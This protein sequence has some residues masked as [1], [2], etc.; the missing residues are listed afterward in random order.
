MILCV[1][2]AGRCDLQIAPRSKIESTDD[3]S[4]REHLDGCQIA[5]PRSLCHSAFGNCIWCCFH[6]LQTRIRI[7]SVH[8][9]ST[10]SRLAERLFL[11]RRPFSTRPT[12][13]VPESHPVHGSETPWRLRPI[14]AMHAPAPVNS[15][16]FLYSCA[17]AKSIIC[18][19]GGIAIAVIA[20]ECAPMTAAAPP[21]DHR[22]S[23]QPAPPEANSADANASAET[24]MVAPQYL[25]PYGVA[26]T[27]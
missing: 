25:S 13:I 16:I 15:Q 21:M 20:L 10:H 8:T 4:T 3:H 17:L 6:R 9:H 2:E 12:S 5:R 24:A 26:I 22:S 23:A 27:P 14:T 1:D 11:R 19:S 18:S 7:R